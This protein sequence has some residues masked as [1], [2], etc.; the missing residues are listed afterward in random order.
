MSTPVVIANDL[1]RKSIVIEADAKVISLSK[2]KQKMPIEL[3]PQ[4][5]LRKA[6]IEK[7]DAEVPSFIKKQTDAL[8]RIRQD[9]INVR[10]QRV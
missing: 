10:R 2:H 6:A 1:K 3:S 5:L 4:A 9:V 7:Q 8:K